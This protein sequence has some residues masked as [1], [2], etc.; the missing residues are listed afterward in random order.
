VGVVSSTVKVQQL[1]FRIVECYGVVLGPGESSLAGCL[2][3][4]GI[5]LSRVA[6]GDERYVVNVARRLNGGVGGG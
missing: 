3:G 5:F 1:G 6:V 2:E 4:P